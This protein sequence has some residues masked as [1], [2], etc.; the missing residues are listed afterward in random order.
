M[1]RSQYTAVLCNQ[2]KAS[3]RPS[4]VSSHTYSFANWTM[5]KTW[6]TWAAVTSQAQLWIQVSHRITL[7]A[8]GTTH[9]LLKI[10]S[11]R[12]IITRRHQ[13][14]I[15]LQLAG[16]TQVSGRFSLPTKLGLTPRLTMALAL[17]IAMR[18]QKTHERSLSAT[19]SCMEAN[20]RQ[21]RARSRPNMTVQ[22]LSIARSQTAANASILWSFRTVSQM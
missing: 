8:Q 14:E 10:I 17:S 6:S 2:V 5:S 9:C 22:K 18:V 12:Q 15:R 7:E 19:Q 13:A 21:K 11:S 1:S 16:M 3:T 20:H 4:S